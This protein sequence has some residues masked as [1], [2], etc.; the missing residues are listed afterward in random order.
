MLAVGGGWTELPTQ[1][2]DVGAR[3]SASAFERGVLDVVL[4][5]VRVDE[6]VDHVEALAKA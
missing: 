6:P 2:G 3:A 4:G 5:R 1:G